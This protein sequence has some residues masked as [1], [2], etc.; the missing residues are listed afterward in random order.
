MRSDSH[1]VLWS[2]LLWGQK[3]RW[4]PSLLYYAYISKWRVDIKLE[5]TTADHHSLLQKGKGYLEMPNYCCCATNCSSSSCKKKNLEQHPWV[6]DITFH[7]FTSAKKNKTMRKHW[8]NMVWR[9]HWEPTKN[10]ALCSMHFIGFKGLIEHQYSGM[11]RKTRDHNHQEGE[12]AVDQMYPLLSWSPLIF[13]RSST[14]HIIASNHLVP[15]VTNRLTFLPSEKA[16]TAKQLT[17]SREMHYGR[18]KTP[19][20][21]EKCVF[22]EIFGNFCNVPTV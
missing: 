7:A 14:L 16:I 10:S 19:C 4:P 2:R 6:K 8:I 5:F 17:A 22:G 12:K 15:C 13:Y 20:W 21:A 11:M 9:K 18:R 1:L 3:S